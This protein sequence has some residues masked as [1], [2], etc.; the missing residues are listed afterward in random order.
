[1]GTEQKKKL[2][3]SN[4]ASDPHAPPD[5]NQGASE[6]SQNPESKVKETAPLNPAPAL[7]FSNG[8]HDTTG[9]VSTHYFFRINLQFF[10]VHRINTGDIRT[11]EV[12]TSAQRRPSNQ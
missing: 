12:A 11:N 4:P 8:S 3:C 1:M 9:K 7:G 5:A 10:R 6:S 2:K